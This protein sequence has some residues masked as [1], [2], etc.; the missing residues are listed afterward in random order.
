MPTAFFLLCCDRSAE[1]AESVFAVM[2]NAVK[3]PGRLSRSAPIEVF[4]MKFFR[5]CFSPTPRWDSSL[6]AVVQNDITTAG[7]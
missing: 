3:H 1:S 5:L 4:W 6:P 7:C 2:L